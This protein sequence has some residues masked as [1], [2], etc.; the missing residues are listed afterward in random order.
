MKIPKNR[1]HQ[2]VAFNHP[3]DIDFQDFMNI[4]KRCT[5]KLYSFLVIDTNFASENFICFRKNLSELI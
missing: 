5:S 1:E 3:S 2:K 4:Y